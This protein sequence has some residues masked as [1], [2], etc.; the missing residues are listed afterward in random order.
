MSVVLH[1]SIAID[2]LVEKDTNSPAAQLV[3]Q[4]ASELVVPTLFWTELMYVL[5]KHVKR[6]HIDRPFRDASLKRVR[7][8]DPRTDLDAAA[9]GPSLDRAQVLGDQFNLTIYD[10][11]YLELAL[12]DDAPLATFDADLTKAA[13][14][15][16]IEVLGA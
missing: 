8:L 2:W 12:R 13:R 10:A 1:N 6:G 4:H 14:T 3:R 9:P 5:G 16:G 7:R 11:V 15:L